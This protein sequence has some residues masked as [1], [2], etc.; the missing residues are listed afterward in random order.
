MAILLN[1]AKH[2]FLDGLVDGL[3]D[4]VV[5]EAVQ[6]TGSAVEVNVC[7]ANVGRAPGCSNGRMAGLIH[8]CT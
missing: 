5:E 7:T 6:P 3:F 2:L 8:P 1:L 4:V